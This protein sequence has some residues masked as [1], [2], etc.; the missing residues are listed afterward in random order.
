MSGHEPLRITIV[1]SR[2]WAFRHIITQLIS[3]EADIQLLYHAEKSVSALKNAPE[4]CSDIFIIH[5]ARPDAAA[6][7][8]AA[9]LHAA[10]PQARLIVFAPIYTAETVHKLI[11]AG[12]YALLLS[13]EPLDD[14]V[15]IIHATHAGQMTIAHEI[16]LLFSFWPP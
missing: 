4:L 10:C 13:Q 2:D 14:L 1:G 6:M 9:A 5:F 16:M 8:L 15:R 3:I 7:E 11:R 12:A